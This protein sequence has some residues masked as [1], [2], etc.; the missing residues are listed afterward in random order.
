MH[1]CLAPWPGLDELSHRELLR[2]ISV[3]RGPL[4]VI[5]IEHGQITEKQ[6]A[7]HLPFLAYKDVIRQHAFIEKLGIGRQNSLALFNDDFLQS[8]FQKHQEIRLAAE[9]KEAAAAEQLE[10]KKRKV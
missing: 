9:A 4:L 3:I 1:N 8:L 6:I 7:D 10:T 2:L 5:F